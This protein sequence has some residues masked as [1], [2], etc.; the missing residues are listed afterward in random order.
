MGW[1]RRILFGGFWRGNPQKLKHE[2]AHLEELIEN[3]E[4]RRR[5]LIESGE[6]EEA[7]RILKFLGIKARKLEDLLRFA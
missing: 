1:L 2:I 7:S 4:K 6:Y 3:L 5:D